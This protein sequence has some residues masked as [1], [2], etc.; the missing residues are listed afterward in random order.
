MQTGGT[1]PLIILLPE[2]GRDNL[3][4]RKRW[5]LVT[6]LLAAMIIVLLLMGLIMDYSA[7]SGTVATG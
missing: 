2:I 7:A 5:T 1:W 3:I 4:G 6:V